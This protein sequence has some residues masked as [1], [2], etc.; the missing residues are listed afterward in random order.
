MEDF[1]VTLPHPANFALHKLII[2][3]RRL[4]ADKAA[5]DRNIA[6]EILKA[7]RGKGESDVVRRVFNSIPKKW[8][9]RVMEG[10]SKSEDKDILAILGSR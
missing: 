2:S 10:L 8:Q 9:A 6:I 3:Q 7:L 4:K 5:K 1:Y